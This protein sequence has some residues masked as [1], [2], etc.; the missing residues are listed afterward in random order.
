MARKKTK[1]ESSPAEKDTAEAEAK[2]DSPPSEVPATTEVTEDASIKASEAE[3][4]AIPNGD[5]NTEK[6]SSTEQ[7]VEA[8]KKKK[9]VKKTVPDW[10]SLSESARKSLPKSQMAKP[11]VQDSIIAAIST[12]GDSK[13]KENR[14]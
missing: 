5:A 2:T 12:C 6:G 11:K 9:P 1:T 3:T 7:A 14:P 4:E 10:A 8:K 13:G